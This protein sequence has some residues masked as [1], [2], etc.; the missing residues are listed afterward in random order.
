M[1]KIYIIHHILYIAIVLFA[2]ACTRNSPS[3]Y[4]GLPDRYDLAYEQIHGHCYDSIPFAVVSLDLYSE[5]LELDENKHIKGTGCN[6]YLS[7]IFVPDSLLEEGV[8]HSIPQDS[9]ATFNFQHSAFRFLPGKSFEGY[10]HGM[11]ILTI[12]EDQVTH[13]QV[14]DSGSFAYRN[15][16]LLFTLYY[17]NAYG[18]R[19][20]YRCHYSGTLIPWLKQ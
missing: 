13:I 1:K 14:L 11:Y 18:S 12:E 15:D 10:P 7:D 20:T 2:I 16:S 19:A 6:L 5:E 8:Y 3:A 4:R 17:R 9:L